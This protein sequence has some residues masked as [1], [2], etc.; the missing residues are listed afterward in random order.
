M[1]RSSFSSRWKRWKEQQLNKT[2]PKTEPEPEKTPELQASG[3]PMRRSAKFAMRSI[4]KFAK[5][6]A[7]VDEELRSQP[8]PSHAPYKGDDESEDEHLAH[9]LVP[10]CCRYCKLYVGRDRVQVSEHLKLRHPEKVTCQT[11]SEVLP[12]EF[13]LLRHLKQHSEEVVEKKRLR[14]SRLMVGIGPMLKILMIIIFGILKKNTTQTQLFLT[15]FRVIEDT[16]FT[17]NTFCMLV[18]AKLLMQCVFS[19]N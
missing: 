11:C 5:L 1:H 17:T 12:S 15:N 2:K 9:D 4:S 3:R 13:M 6:A 14:V 19:I 16:F 7:K 10:E 8:M 18:I